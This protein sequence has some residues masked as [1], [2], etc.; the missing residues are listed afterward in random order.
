MTGSSIP[1]AAEVGPDPIL[2]LSR[3]AIDQSGERTVFTPGA[4]SVSIRGF[5]AGDTFVLIDG[6]RVAD[7]PIGANGT[8]SFVDLNSIPTAAIES[9]DI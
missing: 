3:E 8:E 4:S 2:S 1:S 5:D 6:R 9:I 7:Y